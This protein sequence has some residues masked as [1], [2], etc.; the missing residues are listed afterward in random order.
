MLA[1]DPHAWRRRA[2]V[3]SGVSE[4]KVRARLGKLL[5]Q[6]VSTPF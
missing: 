1:E 4:A 2:L 3:L 5:L 6:A